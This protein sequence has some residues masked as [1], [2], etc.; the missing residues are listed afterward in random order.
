MRSDFNG[1]NMCYLANYSASQMG[2]AI[3]ILGGIAALALILVKLYKSL[4]PQKNEPSGIN[5]NN[6]PLSV[7]MVKQLATK[8]EVQELDREIHQRFDSIE[9]KLDH[10]RMAAR[11]SLGNVHKRIDKH[12]ENTSEI[13][14]ELKQI[15]E[16]LKLLLQQQIK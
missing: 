13:K 5:I 6:N 14:G 2:S 11:A 15:N 7:E 4:I 16:N 1:M 10:E 3:A 12:A 8:E 9:K